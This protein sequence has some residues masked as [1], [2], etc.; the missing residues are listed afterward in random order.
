MMSA[1][2]V[3]LRIAKYEFKKNTEYLLFILSWCASAVLIYYAGELKQYSMDVLAGGLFI[4]Y[5]YNQKRL[6]ETV[7]IK[8]HA[9]IL[10]ALSSLIL[11]SYAAFFFFFMPLYN[12]WKLSRRQKSAFRLFII[13]LVFLSIFCFL[14]Y[15]Y[16]VRLRDTTTLLREWKDYFVSYGSVEVF[17]QTW[18]EGTNN[19]FSR[20]FVER[21]KILKKIGLSFVA[22][23]FLYMF[24]GFFKNIRREQFFVQSLATIPFVV[25]VELFIMGSLHQYPFTVPRTSLFFC[26]VVLFLTVKAMERLKDVYR[27][28]GTILMSLY[29]CFTFFIALALTKISF[30]GELT[31]RPIL[32]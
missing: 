12:F 4:L 11:F 5:L 6:I 15:R 24:I 16:D 9:L 27:P 25:Y 2:F 3:W 30:A 10:A 8:R 7:S 17:F 29:F 13:L 26:P 19:L 28:A 31:F 14:S 22:F 23:G 1:F 21:P 18:G 20:W 32:W